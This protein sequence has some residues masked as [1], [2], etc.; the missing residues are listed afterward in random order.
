[1]LKPRKGNTRDLHKLQ[2]IIRHPYHSKCPTTGHF[3]DQKGS[4]IMLYIQLGS[5]KS[6]FTFMLAC[7]TDRGKLPPFVVFKRTQPK[8]T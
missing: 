5:E 4:K 2:M 1:M 7:T 6:Y 3:V 8:E